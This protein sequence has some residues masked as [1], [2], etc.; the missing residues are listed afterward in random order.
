LVLSQDSQPLARDGAVV[1]A[2]EIFLPLVY[3]G[4][5]DH[6]D[7]GWMRISDQVLSMYEEVIEKVQVE[8]LAGPLPPRPLVALG[9]PANTGGLTVIRRY[10]GKTGKLFEVSMTYHAEKQQVF[11]VELRRQKG[12]SLE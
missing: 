4:I 11:L 10:T 6:P 8:V 2:A 5:I 9:Q 1:S 7:H 12:S 3:A